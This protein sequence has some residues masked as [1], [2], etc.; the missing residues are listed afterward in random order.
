MILV[1][2]KVNIKALKDKDGLLVEI[3]IQ[4]GAKMVPS[5]EVVIFFNNFFFI[6]WKINW[7]FLSYKF[8]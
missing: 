5:S 4:D 8:N 1:F 7:G 2:L 6:F 3:R